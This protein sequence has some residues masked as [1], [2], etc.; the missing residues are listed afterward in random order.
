M[1]IRPSMVSDP[2][3]RFGCIEHDLTIGSKHLPNI[4]KKAEVAEIKSG[5]A[6]FRAAEKDVEGMALKIFT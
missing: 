5:N 1:T 6:Q 3:R 2:V 4:G